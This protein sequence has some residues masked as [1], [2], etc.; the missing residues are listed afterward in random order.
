LKPRHEKVDAKKIEEIYDNSN[1]IS[2]NRLPNGAH[3][4]SMR[5]EVQGIERNTSHLTDEYGR[6]CP[7]C[8]GKG[9][10]IDGY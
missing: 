5:R 7:L 10:V 9:Y 6:I 1:G 4:C 8:D 2:N 3:K